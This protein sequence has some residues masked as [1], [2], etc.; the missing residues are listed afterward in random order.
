MLTVTVQG[1]RPDKSLPP[2]LLPSSRKSAPFS[3]RRGMAQHKRSC[4][5]R[6]IP[7]AVGG[8]VIDNDHGGKVSAYLIH[9]SSD[10]ARFVQARDHRRATGGPIHLHRVGDEPDLPSGNAG[11]QDAPSIDTQQPVPEWPQAARVWFA[12][13]ELARSNRGDDRRLLPRLGGTNCKR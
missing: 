6:L 3:H 2:G 7:G 5:C 4:Q 13:A 9:Q 10:G 1:E 11:A 12:S 8:S